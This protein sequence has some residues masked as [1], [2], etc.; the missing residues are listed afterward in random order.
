M[1]TVNSTIRSKTQNLH[2][3]LFFLRH[4]KLQ[5]CCQISKNGGVESGVLNFERIFLCG[6]KQLAMTIV[7]KLTTVFVNDI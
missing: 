6:S 4:V 7:R 3:L 1:T 5:Y 2:N